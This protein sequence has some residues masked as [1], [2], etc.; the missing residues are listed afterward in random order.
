MGF[1]G[2]I[3]QGLARTTKQIVDRF[4]E[5]VSLADAPDKRS[6]PVDVDTL[7]ALEELLISADVGVAATDRIVAAVR[8]QPG[9]GASPPAF[10]KRGK[11]R[12][13]R[14]RATPP[15][16]PDPPRRTR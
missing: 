2:R 15:A 1:F 3:K 11:P 10:V 13:F 7:D 9:N 5:I 12:E 14:S 16:V 6:R 4:D 8:N